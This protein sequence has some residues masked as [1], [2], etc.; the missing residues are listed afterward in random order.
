M[1]LLL[2]ALCFSEADVDRISK[3]RV[4]DALCKT[5]G[6][7]K[8]EY[9]RLTK[10]CNCVEPKKYPKEARIKLKVKRIGQEY[11]SIY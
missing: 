2:A 4:C 1:W 3:N 8:G 6:F 9:D 5:D 11:E 7:P 10:E